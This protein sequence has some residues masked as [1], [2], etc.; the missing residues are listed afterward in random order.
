MPPPHTQTTE[1]SL[2]QGR[3]TLPVPAPATTRRQSPGYAVEVVPN[4]ERGY[5]AV[6]SFTAYGETHFV[7][8][9]NAPSEAQARQLGDKL[10]DARRKE[11]AQLQ[12]SDRP[13]KRALSDG[14]IESREAA[15]HERD[16][17]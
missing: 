15:R 16:Y 3:T 11:D 4:R 12:R 17:E 13:R 14:E 6:V 5:D 8:A 2:L 10:A 9:L 7:E 1:Q